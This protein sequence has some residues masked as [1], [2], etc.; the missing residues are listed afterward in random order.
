MDQI[1]EFNEYDHKTIFEVLRSAY[2]INNIISGI[3]YNIL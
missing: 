1:A 3:Y 2:I